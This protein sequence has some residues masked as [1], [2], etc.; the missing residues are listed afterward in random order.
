VRLGR[1]SAIPGILTHKSFSALLS[2]IRGIIT[3]LLPESWKNVPGERA[4]RSTDW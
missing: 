1:S 4:Y 2:R 3:R